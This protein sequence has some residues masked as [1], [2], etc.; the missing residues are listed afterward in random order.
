MSLRF[1]CR[2]SLCMTVLCASAASVPASADAR[3][4]GHKHTRYYYDANKIKAKHISCADARKVASAAIRT[5]ASG[6]FEYDGNMGFNGAGR[7]W[8]LSYHAHGSDS[9]FRVHCIE[10]DIGTGKVSFT[11]AP[12]E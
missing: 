8:F 6:P 3:S 4:C 1:L 10:Q 11:T 7:G 12:K 9:P 2:S 5:I